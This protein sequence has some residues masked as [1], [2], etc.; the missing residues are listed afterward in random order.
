MND[1]GTHGVTRMRIA[2][3]QRAASI[4][5]IMRSTEHTLTRKQLQYG[6]DDTFPVRRLGDPG[7]F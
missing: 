4:A 5:V 7:L 1:S 6:V 2:G 3:P